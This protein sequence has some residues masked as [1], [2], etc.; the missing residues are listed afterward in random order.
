MY[1]GGGKIQQIMVGEKKNN[2]YEYFI[3]GLW[4]IH[5]SVLFLDVTD[6]EGLQRSLSGWAVK[7][8]AAVLRDE[9]FSSLLDELM[10]FN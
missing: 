1:G 5:T 2:C 6:V 4:K 8:I 3:Q 9:E 7:C 10:S